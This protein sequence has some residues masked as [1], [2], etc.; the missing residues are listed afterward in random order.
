MK[1]EKPEILVIG[2]VMLDCYWSGS[3]VRISPEAPVPV[4]KMENEEIRLGGA[5]NV[6]LNAI[7]LGANVHLIATI[8]C[9]DDGQRI[10][11]LLNSNS[12]THTLEISKTK[13]TIKKLRANAKN[14]QLLRLDFEDATIDSHSPKITDRWLD[15]VNQHDLTIL[16][17]YNK[18]V[19]NGREQRLIRCAKA[20]SKPVLVDPK[21]T[22]FTKYRGATLIKP[23]IF[24][25]EAIVGPCR[26]E[27]EL[28]Q[29]G[30]NLRESLYLQHL[31][32]TRGEKGMT[33]FTADAPQKH[34]LQR[35]R[36]YL[37]LPERVTQCSRQ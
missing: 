17:D 1:T 32:I 4:L 30:K 11:E 14:H 20:F 2:D 8:G 21:G 13:R 36:K 19:L 33:L 25:F 18:G 37:I 15:L 35:Q 26:H 6:A 22:D 12:I 29:K 16:S 7:S 23:N 9:D 31:L 28:L 34:T 5:G 24:E 27:Q 10:T 3:V